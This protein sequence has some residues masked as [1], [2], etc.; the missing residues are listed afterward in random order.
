MPDEI[1]DEEALNIIRDFVEFLTLE[2]M[3]RSKWT[4]GI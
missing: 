2:K 3:G 1:T 4:T